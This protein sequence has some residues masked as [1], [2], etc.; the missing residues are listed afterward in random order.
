MT[1]QKHSTWSWGGPNSMS[2]YVW[3]KHKEGC[4][5]K[6]LFTQT[7][8]M[9]GQPLWMKKQQAIQNWNWREERKEVPNEL[10]L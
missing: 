4:F 6:S 3:G 7:N 8:Y 9:P 10:Q 5:I 1:V 2:W